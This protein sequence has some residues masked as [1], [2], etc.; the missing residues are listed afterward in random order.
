MG[1]SG[2][3][4]VLYWLK[5]QDKNSRTVK[6]GGWTLHRPH[7]SHSQSQ[8]TSR[9][10]MCRKGS[11]EVEG[12]SCQGMFYP[13][14][15]AVESIMA[16]MCE[17][18]WEEPEIYQTQTVDQANHNDWTKET[19]KN[20]SIEVIHTTTRVWLSNSGTHPLSLPMCLSTCTVLFPPNKHLLHYFPSLWKFFSSKPEARALV[21]DHWSSG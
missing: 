10:H 7:I 1:L 11:L 5:L 18:T 16:E 12:Q 21:T 19:G 14:A 3:R 4:F 15:F 2:R 9:L 20:C 8:E 17:Q 13:Q 6:G